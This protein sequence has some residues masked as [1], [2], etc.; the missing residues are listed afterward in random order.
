MRSSMGWKIGPRAT[1]PARR[2]REGPRIS[3]LDRRRQQRRQVQKLLFPRPLESFGK[4]RSI[5]RLLDPL[6][7]TSADLSRPLCCRP[8]KPGKHQRKYDESSAVLE[9]AVTSEKRT[10]SAEILQ[11]LPSHRD[12]VGERHPQEFL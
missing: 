2:R 7:L 6:S 1:N 4:L 9:K 3:G 11:L 10:S 12:D 5:V 8:E